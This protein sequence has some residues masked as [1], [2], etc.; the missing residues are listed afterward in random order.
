VSAAITFAEYGPPE[1]MKLVD[2]P[3]PQPGPGQ[4]LIRVRA[5]A[6]NPIDLRLRSGAM[7][8]LIPLTLPAIPGQDVAGVVERVGEGSQFSVGDEVFGP[9]DGGYREHAVLDQAFAKPGELTF[10]RAAALVTVGETAVR[11]LHHLDV[12]SGQTLVILGAG[13]SV[14]S[15]ALQLAVARGVT[16]IGTV[17]E[18]DFE[19]IA[20]YGATPVLYGD[21]WADRVRAVAERSVDRVLD[22]VGAGLLED[23]ISLAGGPD[24]VLT[25][26]DPSSADYGVRL[27]GFDPTDRFHEELPGLAEL[28][29]AGKLDFS[30]VRTMPLAQAAEAHRELE[31]NSARG[32]VV[33]IP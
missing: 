31:T 17:G 2:L 23:A 21:G 8:G 5:A 10:E 7:D 9:V 27:T 28:V 25:I 4:V 12:S 3:T 15:V 20:T 1:V 19:R 11:V 33:L 16:V 18:H 24:Q 26:A 30:T 14:A 29:V 32:K 6:I 22:A 13:G